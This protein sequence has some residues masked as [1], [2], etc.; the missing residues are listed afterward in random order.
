MARPDACSYDELPYEDLAFYHTHPSNL[1]VVAA[2]CGLRPP[3]VEACRVLELGCGSGFNLLA[4]AQSLPAARFVGV[5]LSAR[6]IDHGRA[7]AAALGAGRVELHARSV[8]D[9]DASLGQFD[10]VIA[11]GLFSR[12]PEP[13]RAAVLDACRRHLA[14]NGVAYVSYSTYPGWHVR[15]ILRDVL[16]FGA[17]ADAPPLERVRAARAAL[18]RLLGDLPDQD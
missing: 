1:A 8:T 17:P 15:T 6:Q 12:V 16:L 3:P 10:Y 4:M 9:L 7:L 5:D 2:L 18:E 11:H 14:P 13:V